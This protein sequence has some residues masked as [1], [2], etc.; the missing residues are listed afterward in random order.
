MFYR[1]YL[2]CTLHLFIITIILACPLLLPSQ[3]FIFSSYLYFTLIYNTV[4]LII[5]LFLFYLNIDMVFFYCIGLYV[6]SIELV[7][8][9]DFK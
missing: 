4:Y 3:S 2:I 6:Q 5:S 7:W 9:L 1:S 8:I